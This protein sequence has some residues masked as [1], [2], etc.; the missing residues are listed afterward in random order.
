MVRRGPGGRRSALP[1]G[2]RRRTGRWS[3]TPERPRRRRRGPSARCP[4]S[5]RRRPGARRRPLRRAPSPA[6]SSAPSSGTTA[7]RVRSTCD[8]ITPEFPGRPPA[9]RWRSSAHA[10]HAGLVPGCFERRDDG[11]LRVQQVRPGV[12]VRDGEHVQRISSGRNRSK[13]RAYSAMARTIE[14][15][16]RIAPPKPQVSIALGPGPGHPGD[17]AFGMPPWRHAPEPPCSAS[18]S[19]W[20]SSVCS[21]ASSSS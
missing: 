12:A 15:A 21:P 8:R 13:A 17:S 4:P 6:R 5:A 1:R 11:A 16:S 3:R 18:W 2:P 10:A 7:Q 20:S 14:G 19:P 9:R